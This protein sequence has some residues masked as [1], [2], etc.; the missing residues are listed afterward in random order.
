MYLPTGISADLGPGPSF[1]DPL[2]SCY[3]LFLPHK[4]PR[5][6]HFQFSIGPHFWNLSLLI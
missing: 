4:L 2:F 1:D 6:A 3:E 5:K